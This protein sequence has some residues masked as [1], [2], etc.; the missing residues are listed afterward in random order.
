[1]HLSEDGLSCESD[2]C[3]DFQKLIENGT[4]QECDP[5]TRKQDDGKSCTP[6]TNI[7][8]QN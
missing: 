2:V 6:Y 8:N 1:M 5:F 7:C 4:C 3:N